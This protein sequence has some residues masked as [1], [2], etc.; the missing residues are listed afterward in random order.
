M[1]WSSTVLIYRTRWERWALFN[2]TH[3]HT[4]TH[5]H[6]Y[7]GREDVVG[8]GRGAGA[9]GGEH[10]WKR[11]FRNSYWTGAS[12]WRPVKEKEESRV[13][14]T[15]RSTQMGQRKKTHWSAR[16]IRPNGRPLTRRGSDL[17]S[18]PRQTPSNGLRHHSSNYCRNWL[19][20]PS[21]KTVSQQ[22]VFRW[23]S[24]GSKFVTDDSNYIRRFVN[25][26]PRCLRQHK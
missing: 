6:T 26:H 5:T 24:N 7:I 15:S 17:N 12:W 22:T 21:P 9:G 18:T 13:F 23:C 4:H 2:N 10:L 14:E 20:Y 3:T 19:R 25:N 1:M 16:P 8:W 11:Q